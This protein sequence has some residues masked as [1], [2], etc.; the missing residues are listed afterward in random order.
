MTPAVQMQY[1]SLNFLPYVITH[2]SGMRLKSNQDLT[3][4]L[5]ELNGVRADNAHFL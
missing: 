1:D 4:G 3:N 5:S 2:R